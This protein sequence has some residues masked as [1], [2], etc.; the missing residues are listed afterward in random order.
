MFSKMVPQKSRGFKTRVTENPKFQAPIPLYSEPDMTE[1]EVE[2]VKVKLCRNPAQTTS[3]IYKKTYTPWTGHTVE[4]YCK[5]RTTLHEYTQQAPLNNVNKRVGAVT[6]HLSG[7][8]LANWQNVLS[9]LP[10]GHSWN[11][12]AFKTALK[13]CSMMARQEQKRFMKRYVGL[14][15]D[16]LTEAL[17]SQLQQFNKY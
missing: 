11:K 15:S 9:E 3:H 12:E 16:Q 2:K 8:P 1:S 4:G 6:L 17:L 7:T 14:P 10:E 13:Y 5:F